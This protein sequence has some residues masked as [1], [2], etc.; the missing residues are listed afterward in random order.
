[1][2]CFAASLYHARGGSLCRQHFE[3]NAINEMSDASNA[4][5]WRSRRISR[6]FASFSHECL[7]K[8]WPFNRLTKFRWL[9]ACCS[10]CRLGICRLPHH[11]ARVFQ[12][13][14]HLKTRN[15]GRGYSRDDRDSFIFCTLLR[16][17]CWHRRSLYKRFATNESPFL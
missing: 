4:S 3:L 6:R 9:V 2:R 8:S 17:V 12:P 7:P 11:A 5:Y 13:W 15:I 16:T 14:R 10:A 1:M